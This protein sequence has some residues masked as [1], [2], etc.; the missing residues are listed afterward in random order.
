MSP[1]AALP[2]IQT[3]ADG[4]DP[5]AGGALS[6]Q[7]PFNQP[8]VI[9]ALFGAAQALARITDPAFPKQ[10]RENRVANSGK[11]SAPVE[12]ERLLKAFEAGIDVKELAVQHRRTTGAI[13][14]SLV[15]RGR[16]ER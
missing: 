11:A 16:V 9:R 7:N 13:K 12:D 6:D 15:K 14:S 2:I 5:I 1:Q 10:A 3:L 4:I 8:D